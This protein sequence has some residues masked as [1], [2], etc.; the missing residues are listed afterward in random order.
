MDAT[1]LHVVAI[2]S[3]ALL[4]GRGSRDVGLVEGTQ[5]S[6]DFQPSEHTIEI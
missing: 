3:H 1:H 2:E 6:T 5:S 4:D